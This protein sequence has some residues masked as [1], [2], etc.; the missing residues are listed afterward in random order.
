MVG[1]KVS[2][3]GTSTAL[4]ERVQRPLLLIMAGLV[5]FFAPLASGRADEL[6][7]TK[8]Y[9][10]YRTSKGELH[11]ARIIRRYYGVIHPDAVFDSRIDPRLRR[12]ATIAQERANAKTKAR[13][14]HYVKEALVA[15]GAVSSYPKTNYA[16]QAGD[17]LVQNYGFK[18]L[19]VR[20]LMYAAPIGA[21]IVYGSHGAGHVELRTKSGFVSDYFSKNRCYGTYS[22]AVLRELT[23]RKP[24]AYEA[25]GAGCA[26]FCDFRAAHEGRVII[27]HQTWRF[28]MSPRNVQPARSSQRSVAVNVAIYCPKNSD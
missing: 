25:A 18:K 20:D 22:L 11:T 10:N 8:S 12:A 24:R 2:D 13:C 14:W 26:R 27:N 5:C 28:P 16:C 19:S 3:I 9:F 21:V 23:R 6:G 1:E 17:E 15:A 4:N 7:T